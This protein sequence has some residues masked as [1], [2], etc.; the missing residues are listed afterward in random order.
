VTHYRPDVSILVR[1]TTFY[2][3]QPIHTGSETHISFWP[4]GEGALYPEVKQINPKTE[5]SSAMRLRMREVDIMIWRL[6]TRKF[7]A[8]S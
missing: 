7:Y 4:V 8:S 6:D 2:L 5:D 1:A 3:R